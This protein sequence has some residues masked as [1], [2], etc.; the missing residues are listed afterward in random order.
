MNAF[1]QSQVDLN[2]ENDK[3]DFRN[4]SVTIDKDPISILL[5][6]VEDYS[7]DGKHGRADTQ[8]VMTIDP[9]THDMNMVTIPR[10]TRV[11]IE[12]AKE[13]TGTHKINAAYTYGSITGYGAEKLQMETVENLLNIPIDHFVT[14]GFDG[15]RD[16][17]DALGGVDIDIKEGFWEKN[18]YQ[19]DERIYFEQGD[20]HLNGEE[21]LA[22]VRMRKR[23]VNASYGR[24]TRQRQF[25]KATIDQAI[26]A[27]T[28]FKVSDITDILGK[29]VKTDLAA[30]EIFAL[31]KQLAAKNDL[32]MKTIEIKG[33]E[34]TVNNGSYF[35]PEKTDL[36]EVSQQLRQVLG[37]DP[38]DHFTTNAD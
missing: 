36:E 14:V 1:D 29:S 32:S 28:I 16:I 15:F 12:N 8:I 25:L 18:I 20:T 17:V 7:S 35:I 23:S 9:E 5:M 3:S 4:K 13:Y 22:F 31:E 33:T 37:L 34:K 26:S 24:D 27:G 6:G 10:D 21:S 19:N 2:R 30:K 11:T 38:V